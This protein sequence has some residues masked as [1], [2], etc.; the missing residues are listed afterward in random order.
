MTQEGLHIVPT[1][2]L[3]RFYFGRRSNEVMLPLRNQLPS[4]CAYHLTPFTAEW[5]VRKTS[6]AW[7]T[8]DAEPRC[9][10]RQWCDERNMWAAEWNGVVFADESRI[11]LQHHDDRIRI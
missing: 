6:I 9:L 10:R 3:Q 4:V 1:D 8:L 2:G 5:S 11:C 7:S